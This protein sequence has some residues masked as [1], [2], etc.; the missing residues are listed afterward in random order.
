MDFRFCEVTG[1]RRW[2]KVRI[3]GVWN[4]KLKIYSSSL[5]AVSRPQHRHELSVHE[6]RRRRP[7]PQPGGY[8]HGHVGLS[9]LHHAAGVLSAPAGSCS[10]PAAAA[11]AAAASSVLSTATALELLTAA[12]TGRRETQNTL[13][14][15]CEWPWSSLVDFFFSSNRISDPLRQLNWTHLDQKPGLF[16]LPHPC[17]H[18]LPARPPPSP[19]KKS[20]IRSTNTK[21]EENQ[22]PLANFEVTGPFYFIVSPEGRPG[23]IATDSA[24]PE[25]AFCPRHFVCSLNKKT[26][27][28]I[29]SVAYASPPVHLKER[30]TW[31]I[32]RGPAQL[33][34]LKLNYFRSYWRSL[35]SV[36]N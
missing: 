18:F 12:W 26:P 25:K 35:Y 16:S 4:W 5:T 32:H 14:W 20:W 34:R 17:S 11:A 1:Q 6:P 28:K 19:Q 24:P 29:D 7:L 3:S 13:H 33:H 21:G 27:T 31:A 8:G 9:Q 10:T 22:Q 15:L 23:H 2:K 36:L 30:W